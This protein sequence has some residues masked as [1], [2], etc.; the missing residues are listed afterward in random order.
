MSDNETISR[1]TLTDANGEPHE[2]IVGQKHDPLTGGR[3][4]SGLRMVNHV[5][6]T[7]GTPVA[8]LLNTHVGTALA[9]MLEQSDAGG[10][11]TLGELLDELDADTLESLDF[12]LPSAWGAFC[13]AMEHVD[14]E[15]FLP[16]L[17]WHTRRDGNRLAEEDHFNEAYSGNYMEMLKAA[18]RVARINGFFGSLVTSTE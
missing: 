3:G 10:G 8:E 15:A 18:Y 14:I 17:L 5:A 11:V 7:A 9:F 12:E 1:F 6:R 16:Q 13:E 2:Y 4:P